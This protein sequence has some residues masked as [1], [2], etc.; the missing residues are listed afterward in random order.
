MPRAEAIVEECVQRFADWCGGLLQVDVVRGLRDKV[1]KI[2][3]AEIEKYA[4]RLSGLSEKD[5]AMVE[6]LTETL[7][8]HILHDPTVGLKE[9]DASERLEKAASVKA[10]FRLD[11]PP[12]EAHESEHMTTLSPLRMGTRASA[13]ARAQ[14]G[15]FAAELTR[16]S[17]R[18]VEVVIVRTQGDQLSSEGKAPPGGDSAG[19]FVRA[20]D[21]ALRNREIDFAV[22]SLKDVPTADAEGLVLAAVPARADSRDA[23]VVATRHAGR[24]TRRGPPA[25]REGRDVLAAPRLAAPAESGR[26]S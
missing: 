15:A 1:E 10:L 26:T 6:R 13:L 22:H 3:L 9:G 17:G 4:G 11:E 12:D 21:D 2:R 16:R 23:F 7:V 5:R 18:P 19:V 8:G 20:L 25:G 24:E 14:S